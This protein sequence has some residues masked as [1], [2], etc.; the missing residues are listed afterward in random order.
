MA[1]RIAARPRSCLSVPGSDERRIGKAWASDADEIV[2]DLE[3]AVPARHKGSARETVRAV[4]DRAG[5]RPNGGRVAVRVN[6]PGTPWC[7]LDLLACAGTQGLPHS[8]VV[9]KVEGPGDL[10][11]ADRLLDGAEGAAGRRE[12]IAVQ[13]LIETAG[14]LRAVGRIASASRR[15]EALILGYADLAASLGR[16]GD[17]PAEVWLPAQERLLAAGR[18]AGIA[19]IDGPFLDLAD[20]AELRRRTDRVR[21]LGFDG[22]WAVHPGQLDVL[23]TAFTPTAEETRWARAVLAALEDAALRGAGATALDGQMLDEAVAVAARNML[24]RANRANR[25][26]RADQAREGAGS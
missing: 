7:H 19:V 21:Q 4:L 14:G 3:D 15:L 2:I 23:N 22:K 16:A 5:P 25:A 24:A 11:F 26:N 17:A 8:V 9:P 13:A 18:A 10:E 6:A 12:R 20:G 1:D